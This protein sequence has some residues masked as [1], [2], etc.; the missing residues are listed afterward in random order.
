MNIKNNINIFKK[1][2]KYQ[3]SG[4]KLKIELFNYLIK[5]K[6]PLVYVHPINGNV[7]C[8][9]ETTQKFRIIEFNRKMNF[10]NLQNIENFQIVSVPLKAFD[11]RWII[12]GNDNGIMIAG[13]NLF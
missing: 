13:G 2:E 1:I 8:D 12:N 5:N 10:V 7:N 6:L 11:L 9:W 3:N 4:E